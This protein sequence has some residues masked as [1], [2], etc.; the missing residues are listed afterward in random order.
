[1]DEY[2]R[3]WVVRGVALVGAVAWAGGCVTVVHHEDP[4]VVVHREV[5]VEPTHVCTSACQHCFYNGSRVV[6]LER[7]VH[8]QGCGHRWDGHHWVAVGKKT[9]RDAPPPRPTQVHVCSPRCPACFYNGTAVITIAGHHHASGCGHQWNGKHW[10]LA[11]KSKGP[12]NRATPATPPPG[13]RPS[14][15]KRER[16]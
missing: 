8:R 7:H 1:M 3:D 5:Y 9:R 6:V 14:K 11:T 15:V 13:E 16:P 4:P 2:V 12:T 10:V